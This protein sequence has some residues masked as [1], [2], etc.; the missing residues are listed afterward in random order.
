MQDIRV[1][2]R[3]N[4]R[5]SASPARKAAP[6]T[7]VE[8]HRETSRFVVDLRASAPKATFSADII[9]KSPHQWELHVDNAQNSKSQ[10]P[11]I[12]QISKSKS[13]KPKPDTKYQI[14]NT[15]YPKRKPRFALTIPWGKQRLTFGFTISAL[16][17]ALVVPMLGQVG[18]VQTALVDYGLAAAQNLANAGS[19]LR[20]TFSGQ[21]QDPT[22]PN[23]NAQAA[24]QQ[25]ESAYANFV[26]AHDEIKRLGQTTITL[27]SAL[28]GLSS[29]V[30]TGTALLDFG[31]HVA[32]LGKSF[33]DALLAFE[34]VGFD[35]ILAGTEQLTDRLLKAQEH[36]AAA[37]L[38]GM[39]ITQDLKRMD[40]SVLPNE[41]ATQVA[42]VQQQLPMLTAA[43]YDTQQFTQV[44]KN[45][46]GADNP[47]KYV[48]IFQNNAE[49]RPTGGFIG[50]YARLDFYKGQIQQF[51][52]DDVYNIDGQLKVNVVPPRPIQKITGAW[53]FHDANW[54]FDFP[55]SA[56]Q[57][58]LFYEATGHATLDGV[59]ALTPSLLEKVLT[60]TGPI[61]V[62]EHQTTFTAANVIDIL[63]FKV[64]RDF[65]KEINQPK[66]VVADLASRILD[67][68]KTMDATAWG[69][70]A[71]ILLKSLAEKDV[72]FWFRD[73][74]VQEFVN[75][76]GWAGAVSPAPRDYLAV[77]NTN[78]NGYKTDR[79]IAQTVDHEAQ[80]SESGEVIVTTTITRT[81]T[82]GSLQY[83][84][85]NR[86]NSNYLR[87]YVPRGATLL[88]AQGHTRE[89]YQP[90][91]DYDNL[92]F[93]R[94]SGVVATERDLKIDEASGTQIFEESG[95]TVFGNWVYVSP[96]QTT[97]VVYRYRLPFTLDPKRGDTY[98]VLAQKQS[99][100]KPSRFR[101]IV[102]LPHSWQTTWRT[103][104]LRERVDGWRFDTELKQDEFYGFAVSTK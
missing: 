16:A 97:T 77:V 81:H 67:K 56:L 68:L 14:L 1:P 23:F 64:E 31:T 71:S 32:S 4:R 85:Y 22:L 62:P 84:W 27:L 9:H 103:D 15:K 96:G 43:A 87:I 24:S 101:S 57:L 5:V 50:S 48:M 74:A 63:Q 54:Y 33:S 21:P 39:Q 12:K 49:I 98:S 73:E 6:V 40:V 76:Q 66:T 94:D 13:Q 100:M 17:V 42:A 8:L 60:L 75:N 58:N 72:Q 102:T 20:A 65:D 19:A 79:V 61:E 35:K 78:L 86:V 38:A 2:V 55:S 93:R 47:R 18:S 36:L 7:N 51:Y 82:G 90:P 53:S 41:V 83:D 11:K 28:P 10:K 45:I 91:L 37:A 89:K 69:K 34:G 104:N 46:L 59:I 52:I 29:Q 99:G 3:V 92:N 70:L 88:E 25:F 30:K 80:I 44:L 26:H 95:K